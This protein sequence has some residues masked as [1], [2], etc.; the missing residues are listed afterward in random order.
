MSKIL[1]SIAALALL[2][3]ACGT[4]TPETGAAPTTSLPGDAVVSDPL[5][6]AGEGSTL[7]PMGPGISVA[8]LLASSGSGPFLVNGFVF[9]AADGSAVLADAIAESFPPQP[10]GAQVDL[11]GFDL[12][13]LPLTEGP[14]D[15]EIAIT[16]WTDLPVQLLGGLI[17]GEL[18]AD[19]TSS[20]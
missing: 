8:D 15:V 13:Q 3:A 19:P 18:V 14:T 5:P 12:M 9:V 11:Q 2:V 16:A 10:A 1:A 17:D 4:D 6:L 7:A 20:A